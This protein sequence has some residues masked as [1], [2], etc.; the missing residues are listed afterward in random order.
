MARL[1][2]YQAM[3]QSW[4]AAS[5]IPRTLVRDPNDLLRI[6]R[7]RHSLGSGTT[8]LIETVAE[9]GFTARALGASIFIELAVASARAAYTKRYI[10]GLV[11][12]S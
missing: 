6:G 1:S 2:V 10:D 3:G 7:R 5:T 4:V 11:R 8:L 9:H 12:L